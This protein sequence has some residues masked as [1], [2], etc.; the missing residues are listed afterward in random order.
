MAAVGSTADA[1]DILEAFDRALKIALSRAVK[2]VQ[3]EG[4]MMVKEMRRFFDRQLY[5]TVKG[6][7]SRLGRI[8]AKWR[9][10]KAALGLDLRR[11]H[12][13]GGLSKAVGHRT[14]YKRTSNGFVI[15]LKQGAYATRSRIR[16]RKPGSKGRGRRRLADLR[17]N[18]SVK[19]VRVIGY[20]GHYEEQKAPGLGSL[21]KD[22]RKK[23]EKVAKDELEKVLAKVRQSARKAGQFFDVELKIRIDR[24]GL[25]T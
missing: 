21:T 19:S 24:L 7:I 12:A 4:P 15:N 8:S 5:A 17:S 16:T 2:K 9:K 25:E 20:I 22:Q 10:R 3:K 11:G 1:E 23:L 6:K 14:N 18:P 13:G